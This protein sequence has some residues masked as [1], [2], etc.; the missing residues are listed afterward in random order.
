MKV[1]SVDRLRNVAIVG[2]NDTGKTTLVSALLYTSGVTT[3]LNKVEDGNTLTDFDPEEIARSISISLSAV[4]APWRHHK[5]NIID[6]PGLP[7]FSSE[8]R[9]GIRVADAVGL[10]IDGSSG[11]QVSTNRLWKTCEEMEQPVA[12]IATRMDRERADFDTLVLSLREKFGRGVLPLFL[13]IG[14]ESEFSGVVDL[15][16]EKALTFTRDGNGKADE[17]PVPEDLS[18]AVADWRS[19]IVEAVAESDDELMEQFFEEG[20]LTSEELAEGLRKAIATRQIFPVMATAAGHGIGTSAVLDAFVDL[21]P[22]PQDRVPFP[23][24]NI[25]GEATEVELSPDAPASALIFKTNNDPFS[26]RV[27][28]LRVVSGTLNSDS[29][30]WNSRAEE[31][32]RVGHLLHIQGKQGEN[33]DRAICGDIVAVAK[34]K[35]SNTGDTLCDKAAPVKLAFPVAPTPAISFAVEPKS[36]GDDEK[37]GEAVHRLM[38]EDIALHAG[39]DEQTG[40]Y[41]LSGAGQLHVEIA[42]AKLHS[43]FKVDVILHPPKVP[44]RE[45]IRRPAQG[46]GRH[47]KQS[48]GRGQ[49]ADCRISLEPLPRGEEFEFIDEIFGGAIPQNYR[50]AVEKGI[51]EAAELGYSTSFPVVDLRVR[52]QD[53]QYHDVDSSEMAFKI[54]GSLAFKDAMS[55]AAPVLLEPM[56]QVEISLSEEYTGDV[57]SDLSQRRG[58]PQGMDALDG[59]HQ[60]IKALVPMAEMLDYSPALTSMTQGRAS[61]TMNYSHYEEMPANIQ[62]QVIAANKRHEEEEH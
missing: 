33:V 30:F 25:A 29:T 3:R 21:F 55:R 2:H 37:I 49:F 28:L 60:V 58:R 62:Q 39:R 38:D 54:A 56:M 22:S 31:A 11:I 32:E 36:K 57:M 5:V 53:G 34:L 47:K 44:Y 13:P 15:L 20:T 1:D 61:F 51:R 14:Q 50:P 17:G 4:Y 6:C 19:Q 18:E 41:L 52:L 46:H 23:A 9:S 8:I 40:E 48:G 43:R 35:I 45:A 12:L 7:M 42:V 26:G 27:S 16:S 24:T 10:C 59:G